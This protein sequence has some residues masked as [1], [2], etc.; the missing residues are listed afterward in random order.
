[1]GCASSKYYRRCDDDDGFF[2][3]GSSKTAYEEDHFL[4]SDFWDHCGWKF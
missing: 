2:D 3:V 1:M 4:L